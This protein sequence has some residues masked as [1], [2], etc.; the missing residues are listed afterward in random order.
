MDYTLHPIDI[1]GLFSRL[2]T[3]FLPLRENNYS[4]QFLQSKIL[5]YFVVFLFIAKI[6]VVG[7]FSPL[8][9][10]IFFADITKIDLL[11]LLN[12]SREEAG[13]ND[14]TESAILDQ[15]ALLKA[16]DMIK[17]DYFAHQSPA[18]IT[19]W[20]WFK[21]VGYAYAYAGENLAVG[22]TDSSNVFDAW[23]HSAGHKANL[24]NP[25][26]KE[27][28]TAV[29]P[30]FGPNNSTVIV[31]LFGSPISSTI[32]V[33]TP[34][35]SATPKEST[36]PKPEVKPQPTPVVDS[37]KPTTIEVQNSLTPE[38]QE[39]IKEDAVVTEGQVLAQSTQYPSITSYQNSDAKNTWYLR[40]LNFI[41]Y[42][43]ENFFQYIIYIS[44]ILVST[45]L[46]LTFMT[47]ISLQNRN[48]VFRSLL[49]LGILGVSTL[50]N[51]DVL[52]YILHYQPTVIG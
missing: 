44:L 14:V 49:I 36:T 5:L 28:G 15:A 21:Q 7:I 24:L 33:K 39:P 4:P 1:S 23:F 2:K 9:K 31:Q 50:I 46:L 8:P 34:P 42:S 12:Q 29:L 22:Y 48:L 18:G 35:T 32:S 20:F 41:V 13:V 47:D 6:V 19:P 11:N 3:L 26:Y 38:T 10:N 17:N 52:G 37:E 45:I 51:S 16:Q 25:H 30:G 27:V 43:N 40:F